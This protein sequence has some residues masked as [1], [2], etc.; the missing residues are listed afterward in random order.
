MMV[1]PL[2]VSFQIP[3]DYYYSFSVTFCCLIIYRAYVCIKTKLPYVNAI[4]R[5]S[6]TLLYRSIVV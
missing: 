3:V 4:N 5:G 6:T 2:N 1:R